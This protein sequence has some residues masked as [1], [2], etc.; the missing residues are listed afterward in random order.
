MAKPRQIR[1][2]KAAPRLSPDSAQA[3]IRVDGAMGESEALFRAVVNSANEGILVYDRNLVVTAGNLAAER[4]IGLPLAELIGRPGFT[5][6]LRC[7]R[8]DGTPLPPEERPT[9][10]TVRTGQPLHGQVIGIARHDGSINWLAVSTAFL[11]HAG[12]SDYYGI[13][14]TISDITGRRTVEEALRESEEQFRQTFELA[15]SGIA[16]VSLEG[17]FVRVNR[18]LCEILGYLPHELIGRSVKEISF[19]TDRDVTDRERARVYVG[20]VEAARFEKRYL[21]KDGSVVW[22]D[23]AIALARGIDGRPR[24]EI[25]VFDDITERKSTEVALEEQRER[26]RIGQMAAQLII[27]DRDI[28]S[29]RLSWSDSEE[30]LRGPLPRGGHYPLFKDQ[31]HP[32]DRGRF[33]AARD[34]AIDTL[35]GGSVEFRVVR[36]DGSVIWVL[37]RQKVFADASGK[38]TRMLAA[39]LDITERKQAE[40]ALRESE[41]RFRQ[42]FE[43]AGSGIAH[44]GL[45]RRFIRVNR[46]LCEI[47]GYPEHAL[48]GLT[49]R[50]ISHPDDLDVINEQRKRLYAGD[51][52][53]VRVEKRYV[54]MDGSTV[55]VTFSMVV[56]RD[57][58][59][60][61]AYEIAI[62]DDITERKQAEA[63]LRESEERFRSLTQL[64]ADWY[65]EQDAE[66]RFVEM[67]HSIS[68]RTGLESSE[69]IGKRR[70]DLPSPSM[71][72]ADWEKHRQELRAHKPFR[73]L[74]F[75]RIDRDGRL[76]YVV[77]SGE[78]ILD[79]DGRFTGYRGV[80]RDITER[81]EAEAEVQR[82]HEELGRKAAE[83]ER[84]N[85]E[86]GQFAYVASHDLQEPLRM[87]SSYTQLLVRRYGDKL[88]GDAKEFMAYIVDGATRMKQLI[89]DLLAYSRVG[90][91]GKEFRQAPVEGPLR[92]ALM[93]LKNS[94]DESGASVSY[95]ALPTIEADE[96]QLAQ[97]FQNLIGNALKFRSSSVPRIHVSAA[98]K[99]NEYEFAVTD[100]GIG[101]ESQY[102]DRIF[103]V[104]QRLHNKGEYPGTGIGLAIC[105]KVVERHGGRIWVVSEPGAGA[106]FHFT[107]PKRQRE[108]H[109]GEKHD[110]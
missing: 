22:V 1:K 62:F 77:I 6:M 67:S 11:R 88:D 52:D 76:R 25:A 14:S 99:E 50:D 66:L 4:I 71:S 51:I 61:P 87:V 17:R 40:A 57:A 56:E 34:R 36:T 55:W 60:E 65:W 103:M 63:A 8:E 89:E 79:A 110:G 59:G 80:G 30:W 74:E 105:K 37:S 102:F 92:R 82:A 15:A 95:D 12:E 85:A 64:S 27:M 38:A 20:E 97:L 73:D 53:R 69:H 7:V 58:A 26:L 109:T 107:L 42:T 21:R 84:S 98:E 39:L 108:N 93:N 2:E 70:W 10:I 47:L 78:P 100:N 18:S 28:A 94:I 48:L 19:P 35:Q 45:D 46:R 54:R 5:A 106:T 13:V 43:L 29:D 49:G 24:Y 91:R 9:R 96:L 75:S 41:A 33:L 101:I 81:R 68:A 16:H 90:T 44:I 72:E 86:L 3:A 83:L 104:F 23:L 32:E 31:V